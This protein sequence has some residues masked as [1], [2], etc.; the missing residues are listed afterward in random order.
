MDERVKVPASRPEIGAQEGEPIL[1]SDSTATQRVP[2]GD[3]AGMTE[4]PS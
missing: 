3:L 4:R 2:E 1:T